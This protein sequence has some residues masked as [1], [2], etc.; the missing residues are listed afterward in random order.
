MLHNFPL[1]G[2]QSFRPTGQILLNCHP[3]DLKTVSVVDE[4]CAIDHCFLKVTSRGED[5]VVTSSTDGICR[6]W[7]V[8]VSS[9]SLESSMASCQS[10][11]NALFSC[12]ATGAVLTGG[13][14]GSI[15]FSDFSDGECRSFS[16]LHSS[17]VTGL[18]MMDK[19]VI[20][21][22]VDQRI[23][24]WKLDKKGVELVDQL[25]TDVADIQAMA[26]WRPQSDGRALVAVGG[27]G[28]AIYECIST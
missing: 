26:V 5:T 20:S 15:A 28:L 10:G 6:I 4:S 22:S 9:L 27:E 23:A 18:S 2:V 16:R 19:H 13:D 14:D 21:C 1:K 3:Q 25:C 12:G 17:Q 7:T 11:C 8:G 24:V